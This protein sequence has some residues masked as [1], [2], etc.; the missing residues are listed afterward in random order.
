MMD[1]ETIYN[2]YLKIN[3][4]PTL[5]E[6][7]ILAE[8]YS[9]VSKKA[10]EIERAILIAA[11]DERK[12]RNTFDENDLRLFS[13]LE[14]PERYNNAV[15]Y[16][17]QES[18]EFLCFLKEKYYEGL[19]KR[20]LTNK[21][22]NPRSWGISIADRYQINRYNNV[23]KYLNAID[24]HT[25]KRVIEATSIE[26]EIKTILYSELKDFYKTYISSVMDWASKQ[27][28]KNL[29]AYR[30]FQELSNNCDD[31]TKIKGYKKYLKLKS[32]FIRFKTKDNF[33]D[34]VRK[35]TENKYTATINDLAKRIRTKK[36][37]HKNIT[38]K[39]VEDDP[40]LFEMLITDGEIT[41]HARSIW[42]A[43]YSDIV[44]PHYRFIIT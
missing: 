33:I 11:R 13:N 32:F 37:N 22:S 4:Y 38:V 27:F 5:A 9:I 29:K 7:K 43:E 2:D 12:T 42:C 44:T 35:T 17:S 15:E 21:L 18:V 20:K 3:E 19:V 41:M 30:S 23:V 36:L 28:D 31:I 14:I 25:I 39:R 40:K 6:K 24:P 1:K 16:Y 10:K 34:D 26:D 8:R